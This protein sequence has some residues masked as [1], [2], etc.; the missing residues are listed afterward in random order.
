LL[1][2]FR[3]KLVL[4]QH[5][6]FDFAVGNLFGVVTGFEGTRPPLGALLKIAAIIS[7]EALRHSIATGRNRST[8]RKL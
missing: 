2:A 1:G 8:I 6:H 5:R 7:P 3:Q 4:W